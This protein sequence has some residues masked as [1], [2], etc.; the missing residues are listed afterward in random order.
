MALKFADSVFAAIGR[1]LN[2]FLGIGTNLFL[3]FEEAGKRR[4][5]RKQVKI[6]SRNDVRKFV[7]V[8]AVIEKCDS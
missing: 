5:C 6:R 7:F 1:L 8:N 3:E 4:H 2:G